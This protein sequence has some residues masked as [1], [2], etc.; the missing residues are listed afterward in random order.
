MPQ[1][2]NTYVTNHP[3]PTIA[4]IDGYAFGGGFEIACAC[5]IRAAQRGVKL[6]SPR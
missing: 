6:G 1:G 3:E 5:D 4:T 2:L